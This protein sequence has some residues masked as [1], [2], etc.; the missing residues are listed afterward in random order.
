VGKARRKKRGPLDGRELRG[1]VPEQK[2]VPFVWA[3]ALLVASITF[4]VFLPALSNDFVNWDDI[5]LTYENPNI[6][7]LDFGFLKWAFTSVVIASWYPLTLVSFALDYAIWGPEPWGFHLTNVILHSANTFLVALLVCRLVETGR[8]RNEAG[9]VDKAVLVAG[10]VTALFFGIHPLRVESVAWVAER[11][12][13]LYSFFFLL[14]V[15]AYLKYADRAPG[16]TLFYLTSVVFFAMSL[17]S[18]PMAVTLPA[19]LVILDFYPLRRLNLDGGWKGCK[20]VVLEKV[21]FFTLSLVLSLLT[22]WTH[23]QGD[24]LMTLERVPLMERFFVALRAFAFYIYKMVLPINLAPYYPYPED[25]S[26]FAMEYIV[27]IMLLIA[28]TSFCLWSSKRERLFSAVWIYY[29][30]TLVPVIG[31][32]QVGGQAAADRYTYLPSLGPFILAGLAA[33]ASFERFSKKH[34]QALA[35]AAVL[36]ISG[37][38]ANKTVKQIAVWQDSITLWSYEIKLFPEKAL[39]A[40]INLGSAYNDLGRTDEAIEEYKIALRIKP[41]YAEAHNNLGNSY[42]EQGRIDEAIEEYKIALRIKPDHAVAHYNL[43]NAYANLGRTDEAIEEYKKA[44]RIRPDYAEAHN[45]LGNVYDSLGRTDEAI[46]KYKIALRFK[47]DY[48]EA[49]NNLGNVYDS[50]GRTDEAIEK[51]KIAIRHKPDFAEAHNNLGNA[52]GK[53]GLFDIA[54]EEFLT[55]LRLE[56]DFVEIHFNLGVTY[57]AKGLREEAIREFEQVLEMNPQDKEAREV[58]KSLSR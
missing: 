55:A 5:Y 4:V 18:K 8:G 57:K 41:D 38:L 11:K 24:T 47:P 14:S 15:L 1:P 9:G 32:V 51:Y 54:V 50:L 21:P 13:V 20:T 30:V 16:K 17:M 58:L 33:G 23:Q 49:H 46:E 42:Y 6:Q 12:D 2:G 37:V 19:V 40:Y 26:F 7:S 22:V 10:V 53:K 43:G 3:A 48:A 34:F 29:V 44:L 25:I 28:I 27:S 39:I 36:L 35:V 56:P 52:Y 45:N 31:V